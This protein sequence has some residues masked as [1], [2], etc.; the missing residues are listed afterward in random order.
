MQAIKIEK[1]FHDLALE[2]AMLITVKDYCTELNCMRDYG[3]PVHKNTYQMMKNL[4]TD[5]VFC[6]KCKLYANS[7]HNSYSDTEKSD[8]WFDQE[9]KKY[10]KRN[11]IFSATRFTEKGMNKYIA[12]TS[13]EQA[14]KDSAQKATLRIAKGDVVNVMLN[15]PSGSGKSHLAFAIASNVNEV[16]ASKK[17]QLTCLFVDFTTL[18]SKIRETYN[19]NYRGTDTRESI[20]DMVR[21]AD[22]LVLDDVGAE[23]KV[24]SQKGSSDHTYGILFDILNARDGQAS[25]IITSNLSYDQFKQSFDQR[26]TSRLQ[27]NLMKIDFTGITDKR[28]EYGT[29]V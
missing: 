24:Y 1:G 11:S 4:K 9:R 13:Q 23:A 18:V 19:D 17:Q 28:H 14:V 29:S 6:P 27:T 26:V 21:L 10:L 5:E 7:K 20:L 3:Q 15:G 2:K 12:K 16:S 25:T 8:V 22:C